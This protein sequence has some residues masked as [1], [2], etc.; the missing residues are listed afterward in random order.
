MPPSKF[1]AGHGRIR[2][3][4]YIQRSSV[5][6][7]RHDGCAFIQIPIESFQLDEP[8]RTH[9][10]LVY[11]PMRPSTG[12]CEGMFVTSGHVGYVGHKMSSEDAIG[13][14]RWRYEKAIR[15]IRKKRNYAFPKE[16]I[17]VKLV[18]FWRQEP[19]GVLNLRACLTV[20]FPTALE[21]PFSIRL[22]KVENSRWGTQ[23]CF[24]S[25]GRVDRFVA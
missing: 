12:C 6:P 4:D 5:A 25:C 24:C 19:R 22:D 10:C 9:H 2:R 11:E 3:D 14:C 17:E 21:L 15:G 18:N 8:R 13:F 7:T 16:N 20:V 23:R 1:S